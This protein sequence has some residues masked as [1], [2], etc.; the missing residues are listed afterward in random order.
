MADYQTAFTNVLL[1][2]LESSGL[3]PEEIGHIHAHGLSSPRCDQE[4]ATAIQNVVGDRP[5]TTAKSYMGNLGGGSGMVELIASLMAIEKGSLFP[6]MNCDNP[7]PQ[8]G[9][10]IVRESGT[11][12]GDS[13]INLNVSPQGQA[14]S[15][16]LRS[17]Q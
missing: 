14:S 9:C 5:V 17:F 16:V 6:I 4:E 2:A 11:A 10:N 12:P 3:K 13:F 15:V 8:C 7:D 1:G